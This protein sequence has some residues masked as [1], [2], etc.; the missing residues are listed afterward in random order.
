MKAKCLNKGLLT[1]E[2]LL[3]GKVICYRCITMASL[4][5]LIIGTAIY[6][7]QHTQIAT[8]NTGLLIWLTVVLGACLYFG[9]ANKNAKLKENSIEVKDGKVYIVENN[10][11]AQ[12]EALEQIDVQYTCWSYNDQEL[13][14][15]V[16]LRGD[17]IGTVRIATSVEQYDW[18]HVD[19]MMRKTHYM[20]ENKREWSE[21]L[22]SLTAR[23]PFQRH[24]NP[25]T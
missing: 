19:T 16:I 4:F 9:M 3:K 10:E 1:T 13:R 2:D 18:M 12:S 15:A 8:A 11:V 5:V 25:L 24:N 20:V 22:S 7:L 17:A 21:L 6:R 23:S 14:P